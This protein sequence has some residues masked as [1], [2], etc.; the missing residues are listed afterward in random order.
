MESALTIK[1][2]CSCLGHSRVILFELSKLEF[3][4][5]LESTDNLGRSR[6]QYPTMIDG[7]EWIDGSI[8]ND[9]IATGIPVCWSR[10]LLDRDSGGILDVVNHSSKKNANSFDE[11]SRHAA[12]HGY[13]HDVESVERSR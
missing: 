12:E 5:V 8:R 6:R 2:V 13:G 7:Q 11:R 9:T 3:Q 1:C 4:P 10:S